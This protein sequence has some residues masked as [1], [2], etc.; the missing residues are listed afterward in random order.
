[1]FDA[2]DDGGLTVRQLAT[3]TGLH[4][5]TVARHLVALQTTDLA[6]TGGGR[7]WSRN[8]AA[9]DRQQLPSTLAAAATVLD[10]TGT[11]A[12]RAAR[13]ATYREAFT[14]YWTDFAARRG[15]AI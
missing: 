9:G 14:T 1:M 12:R 2:L 11:T 8:L 5:A 13:H 7:T 15:W 6:S 3:L 10:N 4:P